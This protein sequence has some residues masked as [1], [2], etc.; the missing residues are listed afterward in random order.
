[1]FLVANCV[2][3]GFGTVSAPL[4][5]LSCSYPNHGSGYPTVSAKADIIEF[6]IS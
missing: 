3:I 6:I 1:M 5:L 2:F 4:K